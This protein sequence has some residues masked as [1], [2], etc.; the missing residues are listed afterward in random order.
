[1]FLAKDVETV[2]FVH[3]DNCHKIVAGLNYPATIMVS[4][5]RYGTSPRFYS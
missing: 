1:M 4:T 3:F 5:N 2:A